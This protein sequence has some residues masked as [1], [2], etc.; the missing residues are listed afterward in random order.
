MCVLSNVGMP[1]GSHLCLIIHVIGVLKLTSNKDSQI[2]ISAIT[3]C[4]TGGGIGLVD[5][6]EQSCAR[7]QPTG[8]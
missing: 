7:R 4:A 1:A 3:M 6:A 8:S 2:C 5:S